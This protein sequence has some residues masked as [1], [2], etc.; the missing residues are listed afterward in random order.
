MRPERGDQT[1]ATDTP[2]PTPTF[3]PGTTTRPTNAPVSGGTGL[4]GAPGG[5]IGTLAPSGTSI[6]A[7]AA[8]LAALGAL[9]LCFGFGLMGTRLWRRR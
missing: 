8:M 3:I 5:G 4:T 6:P 7:W 9:G 2:V 1:G